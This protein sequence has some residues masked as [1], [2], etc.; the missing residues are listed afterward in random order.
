VTRTRTCLALALTTVLALSACGS[1]DESDAPEASASASATPSQDPNVC[2][3][4]AKEVPAIAGVVA[5]SQDLAVKPKVVKGTQPGPTE[6]QY[7]DI[8]EGDG[9]EVRVGSEAQLKYVGALYDSGKEFDSSWSRGASETFDIKACFPG[10]IAGFSVGP[11]GMREGGR[12]QI[13]IPASF[14]YGEAGSGEAIPPNADLIFIVDVVNVGTPAPAA[15][16]PAP[17][18]PAT[19]APATSAPATPAP[20]TS[21]PATSAPATSAPAAPTTTA[22]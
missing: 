21:A 6:L 19:P 5:A 17:A 16:T 9:E 11:I 22:P 10:S 2:P 18:A 7:F 12:R 14:G 20:A 3:S 8:V 13:I 15:T 4:T 1:D